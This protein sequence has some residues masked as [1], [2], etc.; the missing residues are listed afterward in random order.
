LHKDGSGV[1]PTVKED[2]NLRSA[3]EATIGAIKRPIPGD[4]LPMRGLFRMGTM[5]LGSAAMVNVRR[6]QRY[7]AREERPTGLEGAMQAKK[8]AEEALVAPVWTLLRCCFRPFRWPG[9][10]CHAA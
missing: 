4:Q 1:R 10:F 8:G 2:R 7:L 9:Q 5:V 3:I 6:I